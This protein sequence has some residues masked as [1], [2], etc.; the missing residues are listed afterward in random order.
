VNDLSLTA[1]AAQARYNRWMN[2]TLYAVAA[3]LT[4]EER[5]RDLGAFFRSVHKTLNH[6]LLTDRIWMSRFGVLP[7]PK[8]SSLADE[9][10]DDFDTL[11]VERVK[12][13]AAIEA[14]AHTL[15]PEALAAPI[16]YARSRG[17]VTHPLWYG[18]SHLFNHQTHHRG[19]VTTLLMQL[20][21]DPGLTD[22][23]AMLRG[24]V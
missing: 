6:L 15:T 16:T 12:L 2:E 1:Y 21:H 19:Q 24:E 22:M 18:V 13:D 20:G 8:Y 11:R 4:G 17:E 14:W 5:R 7:A 9:Q 10:Y 23:I 3:K